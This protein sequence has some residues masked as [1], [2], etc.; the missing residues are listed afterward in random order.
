LNIKIIDPIVCQTDK[1]E[2]LKEILTVTKTFWKKGSFGRKEKRQY[3][4]SLVNKDGHFLF[5]FLPRVIKQCELRK[6]PTNTI[7][8]IPKVKYKKGFQY[9]HLTLFP[10][11]EKIVKNA[12]EI[13]RG[14]IK[15]PT[16][17]G[18][19]VIMYAIISPLI[20]SKSLIICSSK[21]ILVQTKNKF[22]EWGFKTS[23][24]D[25]KTKD[26]SGE[27]VVGLINSLHNL[28]IEKHCSI[29]DAVLIDETHHVSSLEGM[30]HQFLS[31]SLA[32]MKIGLTATPNEEL[33]SEAQMASEGLIGPILGLFTFEEAVKAKRIAK[34]KL[35]LLPAPV[36]TNI[37]EVRTYHEI[38]KIG[39]VFN[40]LRNN[41]IADYI[42]E[43]ASNG[44]TCLVFV[45]L[46]EHMDIVISL[47]RKKGVSCEAISGEVESSTRETTKKKL[48]EKKI[49]A[50]VATTAWRE[51]VDIPQLD[52]VINAAGYLSEKP[53][54]QM[55]GRALRISE[56]KEEGT[57]VDIIDSGKYL[58]EHCV[59]RLLVYSDLGW[60]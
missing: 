33:G 20:S 48:I 58:A 24:F 53:I 8:E 21:S 26:L 9:P 19:T 2:E 16:G 57:I 49:M 25:G 54:I 39:I 52:V 56:G 45:R 28:P 7:G 59:R 23:V 4:A 12:L 47:L 31:K 1:P 14:I 41:M 17:T 29:F 3:K 15:S 60:I 55:A 40:R 44:K 13:Q 27:V 38:Y 32:P 6:I 34:P 5:G 22:E 51:G 35:K 30:Y 18:K 46:I 10:D 42:V 37:K 36:N 43:Q 11:Q 50:V